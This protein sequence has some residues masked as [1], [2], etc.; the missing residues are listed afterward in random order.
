M[1]SGASSTWPASAP[2]FARPVRSR[3]RGCG[4][5]NGVPERAGGNR[6]RAGR[7]FRT[8][9]G[10]RGHESRTGFRRARS[11]P[12]RTAGKRGT[13]QSHR[14]LA[15]PGRS[16]GYRSGMAKV[17]RC[18]AFR[19]DQHAGRAWAPAGVIAGEA[20]PRGTDWRARVA[21]PARAARGRWGRLPSTGIQ[22]GHQVTVRRFLARAVILSCIKE[23]PT[24]VASGQSA[25]PEDR[26]VASH[27]GRLIGLVSVFYGCS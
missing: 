10:G 6:F 8:A 15:G 2:A 14:S 18:L 13:R 23:R 5:G 25:V 21:M 26:Q 11:E 17:G 16:A 4:L 9:A 19:L 24:L 20:H 1:I 7:L 22:S 27:R 12:R 3:S